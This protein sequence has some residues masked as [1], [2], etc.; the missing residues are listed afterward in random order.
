MSIGIF[1]TLHVVKE[2]LFTQQS[3]VGVTAHNIANVNTPG[4]SRQNPGIQARDAQILGGVYFGRGAELDSI[5]KSYDQYLN[6]TITIEKSIL[7]RWETQETYLMQTETIFNETNGNGIN[8][9]LNEFWDAWQDLADNPEGRPER[10]ILQTGGENIARQFARMSTGLNQVRS[11]ANNRMASTIEIINSLSAEIA[12]LN[13]QVQG[14]LTQRANANDLTDARDLKIDE[15]SSYMDVT[16]INESD[17]QVTL[18]TGA[19]KLLVSENLSWDL[20]V[21]ANPDN[22]NLY[23][24]YHVDKDLTA[25]ITD[26]IS[27]GSLRGLLYVRD[28]VIPDYIDQ[29]NQLAASLAIEVNKIHYE[30]YGLDGSTGNY[31]FSPDI[32]L[33]IPDADNEGGAQIFDA[34][35]TDPTQLLGSD[36]EIRFLNAAMGTQRY[37]IYDTRNEQTIYRID[38]SNASLVYNDSAGGGGADSIVQLTHGSYTGAELAAE[39]ERVL[40]DQSSTSQNYTITHDEQDRHFIISNNGIESLALNWNDTNSTVGD[41]LGFNDAGTTTIAGNSTDESTLKAGRYEYAGTTFEISSDLNGTIQFVEGVTT[42]NA[43]LTSGVYTGLQLATEIERALEDAGVQNYSVTFNDTIQR[44]SITNNDNTLTL[45]WNNSNAA[46]TLGFNQVASVRAVNVADWG[47]FNKHV[48]RV[49]EISDLDNRII[50]DDGGIGDGTAGPAGS[51]FVTG[52]LTNGNYTGE[53]LAAEFERVLETTAGSAQQDYIVNY[54]TRNGN[55]NIIN[56]SANQTA[57]TLAFSNAGST[58]AATAGYTADST[59]AVGANDSGTWFTGNVVSRDTI[60][61]YGIS[62]RINDETAPPARG[63]IFAVNMVTDAALNL[64][65]NDQTG[66][67]MDIIAAAQNVIKIDA[68]NNTLIFDDDGDLADNTNYRVDI[69]TGSYTPEE[70][71]A[72][73]ERQ[74]EQNGAGQSYSVRY[75]YASHN[76]VFS[77]N[78][79]TANDLVLYWEDPETTIEFELGFS[80]KIFQVAEGN[81][82]ISINENGTNYNITLNPGDFTGENLAQILQDKLQIASRELNG[83]AGVVP[84]EVSY[85]SATRTFTITNPATAPGTLTMNW[86]ADPVL[87]NA[88][89]FAGAGM[90]VT[91]GSSITGTVTNNMLTGQT[92]VSSDFQTGNGEVLPGDNRNAL[93]IASLRSMRI[94]NNDTLSLD[95]FYQILV[96][97]VG[98]D[99][100]TTNRSIIQQEFTLEQLEL[101]R[102]SISGVSID[103]EMVELIKY[104]Q[105]YAANAKMITTLDQMLNDLLNIR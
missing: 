24:I 98:S 103:E 29:L 40:E 26:D 87:S 43:Q 27:E 92:T 66:A 52:T 88:L 71:S 49:F 9:M 76:F 59:I 1:G 77:N 37:E 73:I 93:E 85:N 79:S 13:G 55:F 19:G 67:D 34:M 70:L 12:D 83:D 41:L 25:N 8:Q 47:D 72:E 2:G 100:S 30:G 101:R 10:A 86:N 63:D 39:L 57:L 38:A 81:N 80:D 64:S 44:F 21:Q 56:A 96:G 91:S 32:P 16:V 11:D 104:Q 89:S 61:F 78:S 50:F 95:S 69:E 94:M 105:A 5:Y 74:L 58:F 82:I 51:S 14:T 84:Y 20:A 54:D 23:D 7:G 68:T 48:E 99:V 42:F 17:G 6:R 90:S 60:E 97:D 53:E 35:I 22:A 4:F 75:D 3:A 102:Q 65:M 15:I 62:A 18:L 46:T 33:V 31:F 28:I 45:N 36:F